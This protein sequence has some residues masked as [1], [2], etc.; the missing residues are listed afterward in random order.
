MVYFL[1]Y[2]P[3]VLISGIIFYFLDTRD[4]TFHPLAAAVTI[5]LVAIYTV[6]ILLTNWDNTQFTIFSGLFIAPFCYGACAV[7][8]VIRRRFRKN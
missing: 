4:L 1:F 6:V 2:V 7:A 8:Y 5:S 3:V